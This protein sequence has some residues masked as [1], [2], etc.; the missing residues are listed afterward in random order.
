M[1]VILLLSGLGLL[2][3]FAELFRFKK[4]LYPLIIIGMLGAIAVAASY[5]YYDDGNLAP[6]FNGMVGMVKNAD[7][8][9]VSNH[10]IPNAA[11]LAP[12]HAFFSMF[13]FDQSSVIMTMILLV[14]TLLWFIMAKGFFTDDNNNTDHYAMIILALVGA[15][16]LTCYA[17]MTMLF[18]GI[19]I[20]SIPLYVL[21]GSRKNN[22][23]SNEAAFKYFLMGSFASGFLLFGITL[24]YGA[25]ASFDLWAIA[26]Y[27][28]E[29]AGE[30]NTFIYAGILLMLVG[31]LF[32]IGAAPFHF[33][34]PDVYEGSPTAVTAFMSTV[35][36]T[37]AIVAILRLFNL[38]VFGPIK[39]F[40]VPVISVCV[41]LTFVIGNITAAVQNNVKRMLA[42]SSISHAG[43]LLLAIVAL[44][45]LSPKA[46][47]FY[48][49]AYSVASI[50][51]FTVVLNIMQQ[52]GSDA[53]ENFNGL[54]KKNPLLAVVLTIALLSLAGI[55]P[56]AGFFAKYYVFTAAL[57][58]HPWLVVIGI[59]S[60]LVGVYYYF[61]IIIAMY[62][63]KAENENPIVAT[64]SHQALLFITA[65][66]IIVLGLLPDLILEIGAPDAVNP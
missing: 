34:A 2:A 61:R 13:E 37:A 36:K 54:G 10:I 9:L 40:W 17:N 52:A 33:W 18:L 58:D 3:L 53:I 32:K 46:I 29:H 7:G 62:F 16:I 20:L 6:Y 28:G 45:V 65:V 44:S 27:V 66:I 24:I 57:Q 42:Y 56:T 11:E 63:K 30:N 25:T 31:L 26:F 12:G 43:F 19:E 21:A 14:T 47:F 51:A 50:A 48:T 60:S 8:N 1:K 64:P 15:V 35:V 49:A 39:D 23:S 4:I 38:T 59:L 55:P 22:T 41:G 5:W